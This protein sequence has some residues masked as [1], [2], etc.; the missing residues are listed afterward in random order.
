[1]ISCLIELLFSMSIT[2]EAMWF[3]VAFLIHFL[4]LEHKEIQNPVRK[5]H[6]SSMSSTFWLNIVSSLLK[7]YSTILK[8]F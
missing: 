6:C 7:I 4:E 8:F 3:M 5:F 2:I 1:M